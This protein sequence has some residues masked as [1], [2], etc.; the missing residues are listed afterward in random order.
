VPP[1]SA[2]ATPAPAAPAV[3]PAPPPAAKAPGATP[4]PAAPP[5][6]RPAST[7]PAPLAAA[8]AEL[9]ENEHIELAKAQLAQ[10]I[11]KL[12]PAGAEPCVLHATLEVARRTIVACGSSGIWIVELG[13]EGGD[14]LLQRQPVAGRAVGLY[15]RNGRVWVEVETLSARPLDE[16]DT[17]GAIAVPS[18]A[19]R[20]PLA[21]GPPLAAPPRQPA[22]PPPAERQVEVVILGHVTSSSGGR[23]II[24]LG[25]D[26]G[27]TLSDRIELSVM[28]QS[29]FGPFQNREVLAVG[30]VASV[31]NGQSLVELGIGEDVPVGA[32]AALSL[33]A[34]TQN[35]LAPPRV[36]GLWT[37]AAVLR[38]FF[39]LDRLGIG[40][41]NEL[42]IGYQA[43]GPLRVQLL[44]SPLGFSGA[45]DGST[46]SALGVIIVS[47][48]TRLF[49][50]GLGTGAQTVNDSEYEPGTALTL[51][52]TLRVG[53]LD[54]LNL[55]IRND[56]SLFHS[57]FEYSAF[58]GQAQIP[59]SERGWLVL[60]GG[61]GSVGYGFFEA[62]GKAL[63]TGN[64]TAGSVFLRGTIGYAALFE[65]P[66]YASQGDP[67]STVEE[68][69][70]GGPLIG[71]GMEWRL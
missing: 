50:L 70:H 60:Q 61:G 58:S 31:S 5:A 23:L 43:Q 63:L 36:G 17:S 11:D 1:Q 14:R 49:E 69:D 42:T 33:H 54:G 7:P 46:V 10:R 55:S 53:A 48:D 21:E 19:M 67:F 52:Q 22:A 25:S 12:R 68:I 3:T 35:R 38:P 39:V 40:A 65:S 27:V 66:G 59:V 26:H 9:A 18:D 57:E 16:L 15:S 30:R 56:I 37:L 41:L 34:S 2:G 44:A 64:G 8:P 32:E 71:F 4:T 62:G 13:L 45:D 29:P 20:L 24:D 6:P 51:S 47:F 28:A